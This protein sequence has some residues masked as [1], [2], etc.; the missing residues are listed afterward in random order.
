MWNDAP[1]EWLAGLKAGDQV[2]VDHGGSWHSTRKLY[3]VEKTTATQIVIGATR[4]RRK[5]GCEVGDHY[6]GRIIKPT[7]EVLEA[8]QQEKRESLA[9]AALR[10]FDYNVWRDWPLERKEKLAAILK[11]FMATSKEQG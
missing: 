8:M 6:R 2:V 3:A 5:D 11:E 4:Y 10:A 9:N 1:D 7:A